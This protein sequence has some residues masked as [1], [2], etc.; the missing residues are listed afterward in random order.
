MVH[1]A[2]VI[3][4]LVCL[5][6]A[7]APA[8]AWACTCMSVPAC[9]G[10]WLG[11]DEFAPTVFE[12][13]VVSIVKETHPA[14]SSGRGPYPYLRIEFRDVRGWIGEVSTTVT[15]D[16]NGASCGYLFER[17]R[18]YVVHATR[19][20]ATGDLRAGLCS[21]TKPIEQADE[22]LSY[23]R[24]LSDPVAGGRVFGRASLEPSPF[25]PAPSPDMAP[26]PL[27][28]VEIRLTGPVERDTRTAS[29]G[30]YS[31]TGLPTGVYAIDWNLAEHRV[32]SAR[33][34]TLG[35]IRIENDRSCARVDL[36]YAV[37]GIIAGTL[38]DR[39]GSPIP[40]TIVELRL[41][42]PLDADRPYYTIAPTDALG[43]FEFSRVPPGRYVVGL[44]LSRGP[45][46]S[47]PWVPVRS[48]P[49]DLDP[50]ELRTLAPLVTW[51]MSRVRVRGSV[52]DTQGRPA[53]GQ[54]VA[55][56]PAT[57]L[58]QAAFG[59]TAVSDAGGQ[60]ELELFEGYP[61]TATVVGDRRGTP[62]PFVAGGQAP[63]L[64][65]RTP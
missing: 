32:L 55:V 45:N 8:R 50:G 46:P 29:D 61:Y 49:A 19:N 12:G 48:E 37:N 28:G 23:L 2:W 39:D 52:V 11:G 59:G 36:W 5:A 25:G 7:L 53:A 62:V 42:R 21:Q 51:R 31:F 16:A 57:D 26:T 13:T 63:A 1:R 10:L 33:A 54:R 60:F 35:P 24:T 14:I 44:N 40:S 15:T 64:L 4:G 17:G 20:P 58:G 43:R 18:R 65:L 41:E 30:T 3:S 22:L 27:G 38:V 9:Q 47:S 34:A 56:Q 6:T